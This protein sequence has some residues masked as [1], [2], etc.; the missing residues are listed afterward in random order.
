MEY[1]EVL[2]DRILL[3]TLQ[4][5]CFHTTQLDEAHHVGLLIDADLVDGVV[6][7]DHSSQIVCAAHIYRIRRRG[8]EKLMAIRGQTSQKQ[9]YSDLRMRTNEMI[10]KSTEAHDKLIASLSA[11]GIGLFFTFL[12][13][14]VSGFGQGNVILVTKWLCIS[15]AG[16]LL[17]WAGALTLLLLSHFISI[18][19]LEKRIDHIDC[20]DSDG[21][22]KNEGRCLIKVINFINAIL[23]IAGIAFF[24][25]FVFLALT[26]K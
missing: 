23:T 14:F 25:W 5:G 16:A 1:N 8:Y 22:S 4:C 24:A 7:I 10:L 17:L 20:G 26:T 12:G 13:L 21:L 9:D 19:V 3:Q 18:H 6:V 15:G 2:R 11:G